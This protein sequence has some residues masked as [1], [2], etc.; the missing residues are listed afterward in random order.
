[1]AIAGEV[2]EDPRMVNRNRENHGEEL[3]LKTR[4][5]S[6]DRKEDQR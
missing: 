5:G 6:R 4:E 2:G 3:E 1:M